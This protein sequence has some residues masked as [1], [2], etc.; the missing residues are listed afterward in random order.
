MSVRIGSLAKCA[1]ALVQQ[2]CAASMSALVLN[3]K[4]LSALLQSRHEMQLQH[5]VA[6]IDSVA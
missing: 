2:C 5:Q 6:G 1:P 3:Y 4:A